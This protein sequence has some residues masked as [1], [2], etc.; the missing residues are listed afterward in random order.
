[1]SHETER[2]PVPTNGKGPHPPAEPPIVDEPQE[3]DNAA[4]AFSPA[5][6]AIGFGIIASLLV[7]LVGRLRNRGRSRRR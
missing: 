2:I 3:Q 6:L 5:Q 1:M 7:L 4:L